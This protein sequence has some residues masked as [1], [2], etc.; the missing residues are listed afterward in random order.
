[1]VGAVLRH[2]G[3]AE[4][5]PGNSLHAL[6]GPGDAGYLALHRLS[7]PS[8]YLDAFFFT[9]TALQNALARSVAGRA[10][11][12]VTVAVILE[13]LLHDFGLEFAVGALGDLGQV[14]VLDRIAVDVELEAAAQRG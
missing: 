4:D 3:L 10:I 14:E 1:M 9:R 12:R 8:R 6:I 2:I 7:S 13:H 5:I 11:L